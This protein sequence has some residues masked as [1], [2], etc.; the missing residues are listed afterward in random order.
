VQT[1]IA[2]WTVAVQL[3]FP[4]FLDERGDSVAVCANA[5]GAFDA[6]YVEFSFDVSEDEIGPPRRDGDVTTV[7]AGDA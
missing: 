4:V 2:P 1:G 3:F 7:G 6:E 5:L